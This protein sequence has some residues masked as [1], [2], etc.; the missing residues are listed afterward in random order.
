VVSVV[1]FLTALLLP[2]SVSSR[3]L[4]TPDLVRTADVGGVPGPLKAHVS[5]SASLFTPRLL[6]T[7]RDGT[8]HGSQWVNHGYPGVQIYWRWHFIR[9]IG[10]P[11]ASASIVM[12]AAPRSHQSVAATMQ[13]L[14]HGPRNAYEGGLRD[15][16]V[17]PV[18]IAGFR[19][20]ELD[21]TVTGK[22]AH[23]FIAFGT[24]AFLGADYS[25]DKK[26]A[27]KIVALDVRGKTVVFFLDPW[28]PTYPASRLAAIDN[29]LKSLTFPG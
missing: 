27:F 19:G 13:R 21:G 8:W 25:F 15:L 26:A 17:K 23:T 16:V 10:E 11:R 12:L 7:P 4:T 28:G 29:G 20:Q 14:R 24:Q 6:V 22:G 9:S 1:V 2:G 18:T 5:Y 3:T